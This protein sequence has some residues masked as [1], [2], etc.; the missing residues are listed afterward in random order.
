MDKKMKITLNIAAAVLMVG[1]IAA[2]SFCFAT[3]T[4]IGAFGFLT[5]L[6]GFL[7]FG[8]VWVLLFG[9]GM[10][11]FIA[12]RNRKKQQAD[13][14]NTDDNDE[15][16][17]QYAVGK[18]LQRQQKHIKE[19]SGMASFA[20]VK[21]TEKLRKTSDTVSGALKE[22][23]EFVRYA[24]DRSVSENRQAVEKLEK[25]VKPLADKLSRKQ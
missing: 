22:N 5:T 3:G 21:S 16:D 10:Y 6:K 20:A 25:D 19:A 7:L 11:R 1:A 15:I 12:Y 4:V 24:V 8:A 18:F 17:V 23:G 14:V 2:S 13:L 9:Y